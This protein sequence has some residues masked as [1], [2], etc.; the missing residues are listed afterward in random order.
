[1]RRA[2][3]YGKCHDLYQKESEL[4]RNLG[5]VT[6]FYEKEHLMDVFLDYC[7]DGLQKALKEPEQDIG[8]V[9]QLSRRIDK[10]TPRHEALKKGVGKIF[11]TSGEIELREKLHGIHG[12]MGH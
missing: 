6:E 10:Y 8:Y 11:P 9:N 4:L 5:S 1:M 7:E 2:G 3:R 12:K